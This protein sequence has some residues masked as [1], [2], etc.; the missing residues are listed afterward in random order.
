MERIEFLSNA[1]NATRHPNVLDVGANPLDKPPYSDLVDL[2]LCNLFAF[3]PQEEAFYALID[4]KRPNETYFNA[5]VGHGNAQTLHPMRAIFA[6]TR[7]SGAAIDFAYKRRV[8]YSAKSVP[9]YNFANDELFM[10]SHV[11][12]QPAFTLGQFRDIAPEWF[13]DV[14]FHTDP[15]LID[16][17]V[18]N[19]LKGQNK[20]S[21][22]VVDRVTFANSLAKRMVGRT[23]VLAQ[24][25]NELRALSSSE[26]DQLAD[27][28]RDELRNHLR[29]FEG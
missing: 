18:E 23:G 14:Q 4:A 12:S 22:P 9:L 26:L 6:L 17:L 25:K 27:R 5:A 21:H 29:A 28:A 11:L 13:A 16:T 20:L 3:E 24:N 19:D 10:F 8:N 15:D 7:F 1:L 2:N